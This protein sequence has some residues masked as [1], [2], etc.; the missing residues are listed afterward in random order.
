MCLLATLENTCFCFKGSNDGRGS[1]LPEQQN[2][3]QRQNFS[4]DRKVKKFGSDEDDEENRDRFYKNS[5][6]AKKL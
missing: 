2:Q 6:S 4:A 1:S 3:F 5:I